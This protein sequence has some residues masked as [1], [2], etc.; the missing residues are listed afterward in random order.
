MSSYFEKLLLIV[1]DLHKAHEHGGE[2]DVEINPQLS[3]Y[4]SPKEHLMDTKFYS[5][6]P[7]ADEINEIEKCN[8]ENKLIVVRLSP[9]RAGSCFY[10]FGT[11]LEDISKEIIENLIAYNII[12][13]FYIENDTSIILKPGV[14]IPVT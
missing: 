6:P 2:L 4:E 3:N 5:E 1:D 13:E 9:F 10:V 14:F 12:E 7:S 8:K 11:N